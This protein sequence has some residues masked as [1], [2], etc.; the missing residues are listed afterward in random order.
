VHLA[1]VKNILI[2]DSGSR[3]GGGIRTY[4]LNLFSKYNRNLVNLT[5]SSLGEWGTGDILTKMGEKVVIF[6]ASR[7]RLQTILDIAK[8]VKEN[9]IDL[10]VSHGN[11]SNAYARAAALW[12]GIPSLVAVHSDA[13]FDYPNP[14]LG[15]IYDLADLVTRFPTKKY[16][17]V[18]EYLKDKLVKSG[19]SS[20]KI[21][22]ILNGVAPLRHS[23]EGG[24][25][26]I[27]YRAKNDVV[28]ITTIG[29]LHS[30]K[31]FVELIRACALL[32]TDNWK[33]Q[34]I[35][36][37]DE[38]QKLEQLISPL[39]ITDKVVLLGRIDEARELLGKT[40]IYVQPSIS[41]GFG[42]TVIEAQLAGLPVVV[43]PGGALSEL[44]ESR[45]TGLVATGFMAADIAREIQKFIDEPELAEKCAKQGQT[46]AK[47]IS[48][49]DIWA[50]RTIETYI[51][52]AR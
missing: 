33:L 38:R 28:T 10:V 22:V 11:V 39:G 6:P 13:T 49:I 16:I 14:V 31:N 32:K 17:T 42:L 25:P 48:D 52:A 26:D 24:N 4:Y 30:T 41:E 47:M 35:G 2:I 29:R 44:V 3:F 37:G 51:K 36:E 50:E 21:T 27:L 1:K 45:K 12:S 19:I 20:D 15:T 46:N 40:D 34:I 23:R 43:T 7:F 9:Q 5:Y 8:Y 18:S